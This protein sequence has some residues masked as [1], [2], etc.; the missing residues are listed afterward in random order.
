MRLDSYLVQEGLVASKEKA[1]RLIKEGAV[2]VGEVVICK[3]A[4]QISG[5]SQV[6]LLRDVP[7][8]GRAGEKLA[9]FL[10]A[11]SEI[12]LRGKCVLDIGSSTGG[13]A[14]VALQAGAERV[15]CVDVGR[16]QL[17]ESLRS[18][19][20]IELYEETDIR[21][22]AC[23]RVN[24]LRSDSLGIRADCDP[25]RFP[26]IL[27][28]VSFISLSKILPEIA[29][30]CEYEAILLFKPQFEVG[31]TAKRNHKGVVLQQECVLA[32]LEEFCAECEASGFEVRSR[33]AS[34]LKGKEG[35]EEFFLYLRR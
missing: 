28:D 34:K 18:D 22:F 3:A 17:H 15:V 1:Q 25:L 7:Y 12:S 10:R 30:L 24:D 21:D 29:R 5:D 16:D 11:H 27:C 26:L 8:V 33:E 4:Y 2:R 9:H 31:K 19:V 32:R 23:T 14:Q 13:F 6:E 35:N 20:R